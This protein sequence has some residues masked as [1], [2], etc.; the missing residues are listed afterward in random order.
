MDA[1]TLDLEPA[2]AE[3]VV[4]HF[5]GSPPS[6]QLSLRNNT[7]RLFGFVIT[8]RETVPGG[9]ARV[10]SPRSGLIQPQT[11]VEIEACPGSDISA[12]ETSHVV[13]WRPVLKVEAMRISS[14]AEYFERSE[15]AMLELAR[16]GRGGTR[17]VIPDVI[18]HLT[19]AGREHVIDFGS[20][21]RGRMRIHLQNIGAV[22]LAFI[23]RTGNMHP[24][25]YD[26][27]V[28]LVEPGGFRAVDAHY[29]PIDAHSSGDDV[30]RVAK[31]L[32]R[33]VTPEEAAGGSLEAL[34]EEL[35]LAR[36]G[37]TRNVLRVRSGD[38][39]GA[40]TSGADARTSPLALPPSPPLAR[41]PAPPPAPPPPVLPEELD[42]FVVWAEL[43]QVALDSRA[44]LE[45]HQNVLRLPH[46]SEPPSDAAVG[47]RDAAR[48]EHAAHL[49]AALRQYDTGS[50]PTAELLLAE[51]NGLVE[52]EEDGQLG[53]APLARLA[54]LRR[55]C[56][57]QVDAC[58]RQAARLRSELDDIRRG[59]A[60]QLDELHQL[61]AALKASYEELVMAE[62]RAKLRQAGAEE[63]ARRAKE[64]LQRAEAA[65]REERARLSVL[66]A[67]HRPELLATEPLLQLGEVDGVA[68]PSVLAHGR[69][70]EFYSQVELLAEPPASRHFVYRHVP[71]ARPPLSRAPLSRP[72]LSRSLPRPP[73]CPFS[74]PTP[75]LCAI[76]P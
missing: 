29:A 21:G 41:P 5:R 14:P 71:F 73:M 39:N 60:A 13:L 28:G 46:G 47:E 61:D 55:E 59:E 11:T 40:S 72:P 6:A 9:S 19:K 70:F 33:A 17:L 74:S 36:A 76:D 26:I 43:A 75:L 68:M 2:T 51:Y 44:Q 53:A 64:V 52:A 50:G 24:C 8:P 35:S 62:A 3:E 1:A 57:P 32:S 56:L 27:H 58:V 23:I 12:S 22:P 7:D 48:A 20:R 30:Q 34:F 25:S 16:S 54:A 18:M 42:A 66:A 10:F 15:E 45:R 31:V 38:P 69:R 65:R 63:E 37:Y 4:L 67:A 49:Q